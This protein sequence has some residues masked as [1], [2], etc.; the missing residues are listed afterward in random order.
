MN[1]EEIDLRTLWS[2]GHIPC[3]K[4]AFLWF[5]YNVK[6]CALCKILARLKTLPAKARGR[7]ALPNVWKTPLLG[8]LF[9][10][11]QWVKTNGWQKGKFHFSFPKPKSFKILSFRKRL[12]LFCRLVSNHSRLKK[13]Q[14]FFLCIS[15]CEIESFVVFWAFENNYHLP[16]WKWIYAYQ[17]NCPAHKKKTCD[18]LILYLSIM[19]HEQDFPLFAT[20]VLIL[21]YQQKMYYSSVC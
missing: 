13:F 7:F 4:W 11:P 5:M 19:I 21:H 9:H 15:P 12:R 20:C 16:I 10:G 14:T 2:S 3:Y 1:T 17:N 18:A 8:T 6:I